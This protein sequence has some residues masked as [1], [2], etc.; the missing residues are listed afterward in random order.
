MV[1]KDIFNLGSLRQNIKFDNSD[2][3][4]VVFLEEENPEDQ[5]VNDEKYSNEWNQE[6]EL[7][8][9]SYVLDS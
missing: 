4:F 5:K 6:Y 8:Y 9:S 7:I 3:D 2:Y 1:F